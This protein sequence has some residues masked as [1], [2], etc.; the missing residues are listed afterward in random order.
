LLNL[1]V[2]ISGLLLLT[3]NVAPAN[4]AESLRVGFFPNLTHAQ[5]LTGKATGLF[6]KKTGA[7]IEWRSF[8]AGPSAMEALISGAIDIA[9]VGPNPAVNAFIR[10]NGT[11][12]RIIAGAA[13]GG[14]ALVVRQDG[15]IKSVKDFRDKRVASPEFGNT[16]D[17]ALRHWIKTQGFVPNRDLKILTIKN[18]DI[19]ML[20]QQKS[21]DAAWVPEPWITRLLQEGGG[22]IFLDETKLW[23]EGKFTTA[24]L[25]VRTDFLQRKRDLVKRFVNAHVELSEWIRL[26]PNEAKKTINGELAKIMKKPLPD[27]ILNVSFPRITITY[28]PFVSTILSS[29]RHA[30]ELGYLPGV[31]SN[32]PELSQAF[33]LSL[34][35]ETL[36]ERHL[37]EVRQ[38]KPAKRDR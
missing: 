37:P 35:N 20:F 8:N 28:D 30:W 14:A 7:N 22:T 33:D 11:A 21:L 27:K 31:G 26:H 16:Q 19:L 25:V 5:A 32:P 3:I 38:M 24:V 17:I 18:P 10:S 6:E 15:G 34:L 12:L 2:Y 13:S 23:P 9:Y 4:G 1:F 36:R 29:A